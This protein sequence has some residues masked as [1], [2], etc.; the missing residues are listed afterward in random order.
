M[1]ALL[2]IQHE[3]PQFI[4]QRGRQSRPVPVDSDVAAVPTTQ[5][6]SEATTAALPSTSSASVPSNTSVPTQLSFF[7]AVHTHPAA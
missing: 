6:A 3:H 7:P 1:T 2:H 5:P 4:A